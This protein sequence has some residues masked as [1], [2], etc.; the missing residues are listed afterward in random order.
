[1]NRLSELQWSK[2]KSRVGCVSGV[3]KSEDISLGDYIANFK[4]YYDNVIY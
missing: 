4:L 3:K 1:M 2:F